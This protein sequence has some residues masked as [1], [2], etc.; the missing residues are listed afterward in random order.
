MSFKANF[1]KCFQEISDDREAD[2]FIFN[3]EININTSKLLIKHYIA[4]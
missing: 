2:L 4:I 3:T 1:Q